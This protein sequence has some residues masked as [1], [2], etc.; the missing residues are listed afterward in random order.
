MKAKVQQPFIIRMNTTNIYFY[1]E[2]PPF[3]TDQYDSFFII[4]YKCCIKAF[5]IN[6]N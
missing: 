5:D 2:I 4:D 3:L 6:Y 1:E